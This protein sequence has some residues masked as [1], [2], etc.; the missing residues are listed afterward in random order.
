MVAP[1]LGALS[2]MWETSMGCLVV[3]GVWKIHLHLAVSLS[4]SFP[5]PLLC[6]SNKKL[7]I[8]LK[9]RGKTWVVLPIGAYVLCSFGCQLLKALSNPEPTWKKKKK[10]GLA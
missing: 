10:K 2:P 8:S 7:K 9:S 4:L 3:V 6:I 5:T 1:G